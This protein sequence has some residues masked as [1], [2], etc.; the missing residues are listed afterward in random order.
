[1]ACGTDHPTRVL[2]IGGSGH[3]G[4]E[5]CRELV[6]GGSRLAFTC[7]HGAGRAGE[8]SASLSDTGHRTHSFALDLEDLQNVTQVVRSAEEVLGGLDALV[9]ASGL[10]TGQPWTGHQPGFFEITPTGFNT[11]MAVNVRG[12]FFACQEASR[13]MSAGRGGRI[14]IV[15]SV[16]GVKPVPSPP[17]YACSKSALW[18]LTQSLSKE[19]GRAGILVNLVAPGILSGGIACYLSQELMKDY[20]RHSALRRVGTASEIARVVAFLV[21]PRNTYLT[22]QAVVLDGGL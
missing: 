17:D 10:A 2:V 1:M 8:L 3:V 5:I 13:I 18:G 4:A 6:A 20:L 22:G 19:L 21:S 14:A 16:D 9:V 12:V 7:H 15:G 11:L